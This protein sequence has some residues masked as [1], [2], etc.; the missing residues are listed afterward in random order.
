MSG[1]GSSNFP[2]VVLH[3]VHTI[4]IVAGLLNPQ[5]CFETAR[6]ETAQSR[7]ITLPAGITIRVTLETCPSVNRLLVS[8]E[9]IERSFG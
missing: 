2:G 1:R 5:W 4:H 6:A 8:R 9:K 3:E 7:K